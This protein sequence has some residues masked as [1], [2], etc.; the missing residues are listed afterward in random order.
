[1]SSIGTPT[2]MVVGS[3]FAGFH[4]AR[5][6]ERA[7]PAGAADLVLVGPHD[8]LVYSPLLPN[9]AAGVTEPRHVTVSLHE[10]LDRTR[11][12]PGRVEAVDRAAR[13]V[14]V[15]GVDGVVRT[16]GWSRLVLA[17]GA[18]TRMPDVPGLA[19]HAL[20]V[21]TLAD[22]TRLRDHVVRQL[23]LADAADDPAERRAR[24]TF[25]V[26]GAGY[27]GS[28]TAAQLARFCRR[29]LRDY[30]RLRGGRASWLL[31]D[32]A[33][34]VLPELGRRLGERA[35]RSLSRAGVEVRLATTVTAVSQGELTLS[36]GSVV[37][38]HTLV[39]A[40]GVAPNPV[41]EQ[42]GLP[43]RAGRIAVDAHLRVE[44]TTDVF[45]LGDAAAIPDVTRPGR[46]TP[47]TGQHA[48]REGLAVARNVAASL[49][50]G[51]ASPFT[52]RD[53]GLVVDLGP[54]TAVGRPLGVPVWGLLGALLTRGYH[55]LAL[56]SGA[57]RVRLALD[58]LLDLA[59]PP[60]LTRIGHLREYGAER[61][62][63]RDLDRLAS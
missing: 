58:W 34:H 26:V 6:L 32:V 20:G 7:L 54:F 21:K 22:A 63:H 15:R 12:E 13:T 42:L 61:P 36:D 35:L 43:T 18:V 3:G 57:G 44:G 49:G 59:L 48:Q 1:M 33:D 62:S 37:A 53:L 47:Q 56:P 38:A 17:P 51:Q 27:A 52:H 10:A 41:V 30:R 14:T 25:V 29:A 16:L 5:A 46:L 2:V 39:W 40:A 31:V 55:L 4:A 8:H 24:T 11:Y 19:E 9:V 45:A 28:E 60:Q 23:D 50:H